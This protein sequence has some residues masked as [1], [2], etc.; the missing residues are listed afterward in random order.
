[1]NDKLFNELYAVNVNDYVEQK[2]GLTYLSW[3]SAWA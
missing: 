2:N 1:M 3:A